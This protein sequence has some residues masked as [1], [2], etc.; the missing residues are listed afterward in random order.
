[1]LAYQRAMFG[2][3]NDENDS[4]ACEKQVNHDNDTFQALMMIAK[5]VG[6]RVDPP[7]NSSKFGGSLP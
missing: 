5:Y 1:M 6:T 4:N 7:I 3:A 2:K